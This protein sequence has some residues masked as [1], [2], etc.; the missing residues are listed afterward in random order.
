M[1]NTGRIIADGNFVFVASPVPMPDSGSS[2]AAS[3]GRLLTDEL[4]PI[5]IYLEK[6]RNGLY[7]L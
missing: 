6:A 7:C 2:A 1:E 5:E 3:D 4:N